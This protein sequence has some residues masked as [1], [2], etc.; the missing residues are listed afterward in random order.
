[1]CVCVHVIVILLID[2]TP[3]ITTSS[4]ISIFDSSVLPSVTVTVGS[5]NPA[6]TPPSLSYY[7]IDL[8]M[9]VSFIQ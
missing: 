2:T 9:I 4:A 8:H 7:L 3:P 1:M 5:S 6:E